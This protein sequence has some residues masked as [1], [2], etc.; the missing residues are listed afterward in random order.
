MDGLGRSAS[1]EL[2]ETDGGRVRMDDLAIAAGPAT[3]ALAAR[4]PIGW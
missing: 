4:V 3:E 1:H 2:A